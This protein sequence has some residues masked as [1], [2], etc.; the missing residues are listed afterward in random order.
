M[1]LLVQHWWYS[2]TLFTNSIYVL[3][4][5]RLSYLC[6]LIINLFININ[7]WCFTH[8][9]LYSGFPPP[10]LFVFVSHLNKL[11]QEAFTVIPQFNFPF[12]YF[13]SIVF[14]F[15]SLTSLT[16]AA[17][18]L[19]SRT[20]SVMEVEPSVFYI[21]FCLN[22]NLKMFI[23]KRKGMHVWETFSKARYICRVDGGKLCFTYLLLR[24]WRLAGPGWRQASE[25]SPSTGF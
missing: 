16:T 6:V 15:L 3:I 21:C 20:W 18:S 2:C 4:E 1:L 11:L 10:Q 9:F 19:L 12:S 8:Y 22:S 17:Y 24:I 23:K 5:F 7:F 25:Q 14:F 13:P